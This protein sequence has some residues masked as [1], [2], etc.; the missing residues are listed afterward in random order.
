MFDGL[1]PETGYNTLDFG[2]YLS[3]VLLDT[4]HTSKVAGAQTEWLDKALAARRDL[5]HTIVV[6]HVPAYPSHRNPKG[7]VSKDGKKVFGTGE[8]QREHWVPLFDKHRVPVVLEHH[9]HT[10]KRTKPLVGGLQNDNGVLYLGDGSWGRLRIPR[11]DDQLNVMVKTSDDFHISLHRLQGSERFHLA[12][13][14]TGKVMDMAR[15]GQRKLGI[16]TAGG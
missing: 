1:F 2:D 13:G 3:L 9:D 4:N 16:V 10:F 6:N 7:T 11:P 15:S 12:L 8:D 5:P 14:T